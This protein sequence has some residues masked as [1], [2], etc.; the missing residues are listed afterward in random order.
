MTLLKTMAYGLVHM[1]II[2]WLKLLAH[3]YALF[4]PLPITQGN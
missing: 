3:F 1:Y 4:F 2:N